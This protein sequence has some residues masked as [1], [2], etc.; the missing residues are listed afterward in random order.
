MGA[1]LFSGKLTVQAKTETRDRPRV[2][3]DIVILIG[4]AITLR[5][6]TALLLRV[7]GYM[8]AYYYYAGAQRIAEGYGLT[9]PFIWNYLNQPLTLPMPAF[10]YWMPLTSFL[11]V[12]FFAL[13]G[14]SF[15]AAKVPF[16]ILASCLPIIAY[17]VSYRLAPTRRHAIIA[18]LLTALAP[19]YVK[20]WITTDTAVPFA[21]TASLALLAMLKAIKPGRWGLCKVANGRRDRRGNPPVVTPIRAGTGALPLPAKR[22]GWFAL[23]GGLVGL[24]HLARADAPLLFVAFLLAALWPGVGVAPLRARVKQLAA[25]FL[26]AG[27]AYVAIMSPWLWHNWQ[28]TGSLL[29]GAGGDSIFL[30]NYDD[31][32]RYGRTVDW[33]SYLEWGWPAIL[34]SKLEAI[35]KNLLTVIGVFLGFFLAPFAAWE[36]W[37][38]RRET[39]VRLVFWY[40]IL[41][42]AA[43]TLLFTFPGQRG[44]LLH[45]GAALL[46]F[47]MPLGVHGLDRAI[48][49]IAARRENWNAERTSRV[50]GAGMAVI[51]ILLGAVLF[52]QALTGSADGTPGWN[53]QYGGYRQ[54]GEWLDARDV[55]ADAPVMVVNPPAFYYYTGRYAIAIPNEPAPV[56]AEV[57]ERFDVPY[58]VL[59]RNHPAPLDGLFDEMEHD[60]NLTPVEGWDPGELEVRLY[61]CHQTDGN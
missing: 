33:K 1:Q 4:V 32:Y 52:L 18:G 29:N 26:A 24:S 39:L 14:V 36:M 12:P 5:A 57:C 48:T 25:G 11:I 41:L 50:F 30:R 31:L 37:A 49:W 13:F 40:L 45:S 53:T 59:E 61:R 3:P 42:Y 38:R 9:E 23:A 27:L 21:L 55:P 35:G 15:R 22:W 19:F 43:M 56:V 8:D 2:W 7:P 16:I 58:L 60:P 28:T 46:P 47:L 44:S 17:Y 10:Q 51:F 34:Q 20:F 54:V 6:L